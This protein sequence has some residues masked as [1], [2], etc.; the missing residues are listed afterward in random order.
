M[1]HQ[2][3]DDRHETV[4]R[5]RPSP[6]APPSA[7]Q[8]KCTALF[9]AHLHL[10]ND[11][12]GS[13]ATTRFSREMTAAGPGRESLVALLGDTGTYKSRL[14][15]AFLSAGFQHGPCVAVLVTTSPMNR[16]KLA[17]LLETQEPK[18][19]R[20]ERFSEDFAKK[21]LIVRYVTPHYLTSSGFFHILEKNILYA[22]KLAKDQDADA[23]IR[24]VLDD[25]NALLASHPNLRDDPLLLQAM[26]ELLRHHRLNALIVSTQ[27][28][29]PSVMPSAQCSRSE[30]ARDAPYLHLAGALLWNPSRG[31]HNLSGRVIPASADNLRVASLARV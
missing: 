2:G 19:V 29:T 18:D 16:S 28:G 27:T 1:S 5:D 23:E 15:R 14:A 26:R 22:E 13:T 31:D 21:H 6:A 11:L 7:S 30:D 25:W 4:V 3:K 24:F 8:A 12:I 9:P 17:G 20:R 10:L